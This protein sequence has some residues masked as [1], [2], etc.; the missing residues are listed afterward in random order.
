MSQNSSFNILA[1]DWNYVENRA[2]DHIRHN[3]DR[4]RIRNQMSKLLTK[5]ICIDSFRF[6]FPQKVVMTHTG[7]QA[8]KP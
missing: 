1:G 8:H 3:T 5:Y 4:P 6:L 7:L 2:L